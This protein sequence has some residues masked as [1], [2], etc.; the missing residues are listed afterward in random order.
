MSETKEKLIAEAREYVEE[1]SSRVQSAIDDLQAALKLETKGSMGDKYETGRAMLH[2][3]YE[4]LSGQMEQYRRLKK[5]I[6]SIPPGKQEKAGFGSLVKTTA[7]NYFIAIP[8]GEMEA[9]SQKYFA[10]GVGSPVALAILYKEENDEFI[11]NGNTHKILE[12]E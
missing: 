10:V 5:T 11:L 7:A 12:I 3:E 1:R 8:A 4:K 9:D 2:L 6:N